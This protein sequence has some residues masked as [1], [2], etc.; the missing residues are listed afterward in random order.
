MTGIWA[1][2]ETLIFQQMVKHLVT[3]DSACPP[4]PDPAL[5]DC[6]ALPYLE[7]SLREGVMRQGAEELLP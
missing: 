2:V 6:V 7:V 5:C 4:D 1:F 3:E